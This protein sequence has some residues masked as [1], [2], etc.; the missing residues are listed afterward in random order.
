[1]IEVNNDVTRAKEVQAALEESNRKLNRANAELTSFASEVAHDFKE[2]L[3]GISLMVQ[4]LSRSL[5]SSSSEAPQEQ[6][7]DILRNSQRLDSLTDALLNYAT[8]DKPAENI[9]LIA[10]DQVLMEVKAGL[11]PLIEKCNA[12]LSWEN[13]RRACSRVCILRLLQNLMVNAIEFARLGVRPIV[14]V[15]ATRVQSEWQIDVADNGRGIVPEYLETIF[16]PLKRLHGSEISGS[17]LGLAICKRI[18][19]GEGG[20]IW[21]DSEHRVGSTF[22]FTLK[23]I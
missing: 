13:A 3:R 17:G 15:S 14:R 20:R 7:D 12:D 9:E 19:E 6:M 16:A 18:V 5:E 22:H 21:A 23:A 2:P 4:L 11:D 10:L 1:V 8:V